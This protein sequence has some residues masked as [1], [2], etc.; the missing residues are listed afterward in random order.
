MRVRPILI[1]AFC[2]A[3][4]G[5]EAASTSSLNPFNWFG[6]GTEAEVVL[7]PDGLPADPRPL[8]GQVTEVVAE[9]A[10]GGVIVRATG[11]P[12][13]LGFW[14]ADLV[15]ADR[16]LRPDENGVLTLDFRALPPVTP[17]PP[18]SPAARS[19]VTGFFLSAQTLSGVRSIAVRAEGNTRSVR[20]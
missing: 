11:L 13:T 4:A 7:A 5:C 18:G 1:L 10:P 6:G 17:Q 8:I 3:L 20:P 14:N 15:P 16:D 2:A 19:I 9:R 12:P